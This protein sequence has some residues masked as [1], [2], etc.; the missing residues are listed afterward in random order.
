[1]KII[2]CF[3]SNS[4]IFRSQVLGIVE[5]WAQVRWVFIVMRHSRV[6]LIDQV[7][8][9]V[10]EVVRFLGV[11]LQVLVLVTTFTRLG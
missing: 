1:M 3:N 9:L 6:R 2:M 4:S 7:P 11:E 8:V 10:R 5:L